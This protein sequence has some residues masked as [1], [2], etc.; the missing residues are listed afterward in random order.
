MGRCPRCPPNFRNKAWR[1]PAASGQRASC[2]SWLCQSRPPSW[3]AQNPRSQSR[4]PPS[5]A[6]SCDCPWWDPG[7]LAFSQALSPRPGDLVMTGPACDCSLGLLSWPRKAQTWARAGS[8][9]GQSKCLSFFAHETG[10]IPRLR[11][12]VLSKRSKRSLPPHH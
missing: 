5:A 7:S 11:H 6:P 9:G 8:W 1:V 12:K 3:A 4:P 2:D 10:R